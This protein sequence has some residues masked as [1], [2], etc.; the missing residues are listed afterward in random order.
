MARR[1]RL[2]ISAT[3]GRLSSATSTA[4]G[5]VCVTPGRLP[6][7]V[8]V[9]PN[10]PSPLAHAR[11]APANRDGPMSGRVTSRKTSQRPAPS[12]RAASSKRRS[13][14]RSPA[15]TVST[16]NGAETKKAARTAASVVNG[17]RMPKRPSSTGPM[18]PARPN[19]KAITTPTATSRRP[20]TPLF[21]WATPRAG[22][23][24]A[25]RSLCTQKR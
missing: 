7:N 24:R 11:T 19:A 12:V 18:S 25:C 5:S 21:A 4:S 2:S 1:S 8:M 10:S 16:R 3:S 13:I 23:C 15:S 20:G 6:A 17:R 14:E 9:A 22:D